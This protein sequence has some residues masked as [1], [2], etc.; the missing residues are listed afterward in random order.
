[1][2]Y[3][4]SAIALIILV[5]SGTLAQAEPVSPS[6]HIAV[7]P[8]VALNANGD[9]A[10]LWVDRA[11]ELSGEH[12]GHDR[13][14]SYT[15]LYVAIS[16][17]GGISFDPPTKVNHDAGVVWG[18]S[19][20]RPR[21]VGSADGTWH[22]TY[23]ANEIHP[24]HDKPALTSHYTR[25][26][27]G[28]RT[29]EAPRRASTLTNSDLSEMIHG[30]F[31][32]AAA[33]QTITAVPDGSIHLFWIDTRHMSQEQNTGA[34]YAAVSRDGGATFGSDQEIFAANV[35]P[36]CQ[37]MATASAGADILVTMRDVSPDGFR[38]ST[39]TRFGP[40]GAIKNDRVA[41]GTTPWQ[42]DACP[43]KPTAVA[44]K[45]D[46]V[47][48]AVYSG[49][50]EEP[51]VFFSSS[52]DG[53]KSFVRAT[54]THPDALIS[55][56]PSIAVNDSHVLV[57]WHGKTNG[58]RQIFYRMYDL[59]GSPVGNIAAIDSGSEHASSP[60]VVALP[61][62]GF[63]VAWE[64]EDRIHTTVLPSIPGETEVGLR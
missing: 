24:E 46:A 63:R 23:A 16:H 8:D 30:G 2:V 56:A 60:V 33:F 4:K 18:Q 1:M 42:I 47:F 9:L 64:Q 28:G 55:D 62:G 50:E 57:A 22:I 25:S 45:E 3:F 10:M 15:D 14:L 27:D 38:Q 49:G 19:V 7:A 41:M 21:I 13:H 34:L 39:V 43:L 59:T 61:D 29:F 31:M 5:F 37:L 20:S 26:T 58:P 35:C 48:S 6:G 53:G 51:G 40:D 12:S 36:C 54:P 44:I 52:V 32:S 17:D 11:P